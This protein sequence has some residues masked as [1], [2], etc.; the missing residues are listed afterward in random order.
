MKG[1]SRE[2]QKTILKWINIVQAGHSQDQEN[3]GNF[4]YVEDPLFIIKWNEIGLKQRQTEKATII[5]G[6]ISK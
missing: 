1:L 4:L 2:T 5:D 6:N 3:E